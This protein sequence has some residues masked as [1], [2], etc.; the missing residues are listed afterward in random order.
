MSWPGYLELHPFKEHPKV[1]SHKFGDFLTPHPLPWWKIGPVICKEKHT[2]Y[3][4]DNNK[5]DDL[6]KRWGCSPP[7]HKL[8]NM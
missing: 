8:S 3:E 1:A 7:P 4:K 2:T 6:R 5:G